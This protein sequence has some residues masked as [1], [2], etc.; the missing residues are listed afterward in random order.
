MMDFDFEDNF[1]APNADIYG[2]SGLDTTAPSFALTDISSRG[3]DMMMY[4]TSGMEPSSLSNESRDI[5][6]SNDS[7]TED[8]LQRLRD[9]LRESGGNSDSVM[10]KIQT[11]FASKSQDSLRKQIEQQMPRQFSVPEKSAPTA[12][13]S[14]PSLE[15]PLPKKRTPKPKTT[16]TS[17]DNDDDAPSG[18]LVPAEEEVPGID[19]SSDGDYEEPPGGRKR[20]SAGGKGTGAKKKTPAQKQEGTKPGAPRQK[21]PKLSDDSSKT[22]AVSGRSPVAAPPILYGPDGQKISMSVLPPGAF[23][24]PGIPVNPPPPPPGTVPGAGPVK[25]SQPH[26]HAPYPPQASLQAGGALGPS[27]Y[28]PNVRQ[29]MEALMAENDLLLRCIKEYIQDPMRN[30]DY[31]LR[32]RENTFDLLRLCSRQ[33]ACFAHMPVLPVRIQSLQSLIQGAHSARFRETI[34]QRPSYAMPAPPPMVSP[35]PSSLMPPP[36][37]SQSHT[38]QMQSDYHNMRPPQAPGAGYM[39]QHHSPHQMQT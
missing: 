37:V 26:Y 7:W 10:N 12:S 4:S 3:D 9:I 27:G 19:A 30:L 6:E 23:A 33:P 38:N 2:D 8:E 36:P 31:M 29:Q 39:W 28:S 1:P 25:L 15:K 18:D 35:P 16:A 20:K 34:Q 21:R 5:N 22:P 17:P 13:K 14:A 24:G 11:V 32:F